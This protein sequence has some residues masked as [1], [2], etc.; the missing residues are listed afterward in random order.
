MKSA[1]S[2]RKYA[3]NTT[4]GLI[5][6]F[7]DHTHTHTH[8][9]AHTSFYYWLVACVLLRIVRWQTLNSRS[10]VGDWNTWWGWADS[11]SITITSVPLTLYRC[12]CCYL[13][14]FLQG[15]SSSLFPWLRCSPAVNLFS[16]KSCTLQACH[17][18]STWRNRHCLYRS[19][20]TLCTSMV[21][22]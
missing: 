10:H 15:G 22:N 3:F 7:A 13:D 11:T 14:Y 9:H 12:R 2:T 8:T 6:F 17:R 19:G 18:W 16:W 21:V 1:I 20:F 4:R 5:S